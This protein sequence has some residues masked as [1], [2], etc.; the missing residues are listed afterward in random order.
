MHWAAC[1][2]CV[3]TA[4]RIAQIMKTFIMVRKAVELQ[5]VPPINKTGF[6]GGGVFSY[7]S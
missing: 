5:S 3:L 7:A 1:S 6:G 4:A 2:S